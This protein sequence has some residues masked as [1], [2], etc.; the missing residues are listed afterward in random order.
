[1]SK[2][3]VSVL[4]MGN[5]TQIGTIDYSNLVYTC[6]KDDIAKFEL[7][8]GDLLF[9]RTNS[10]EWVGKTSLY[11]GKIPAIYAGYLIRIR[12]IG[13]DPNFLCMYMCSQYY[14]DW[15]LQ[16]KTDAVNQSNINAQKLSKLYC[17]IPPLKEQRRIVSIFNNIIAILTQIELSKSILISTITGIKS[18][19]LELAVQGKLV[20]QDPTDEPAADMLKRVNPKA[21]IITDNPHYP[22]LP[23]NWVLASLTDVCESKLGKTLNN[24]TDEGIIQ[25]YLCSINV[26]QGAFDL[27]VLKTAKIDPSEYERY[28]VYNGDLLI[29]E[30][31]DVGRCA[32]WKG[33]R[34][35]YQN[36][37]HRVRPL[38][39]VDQ[40][41]L[42]YLVLYAKN[43]LWIE[44]LSSGV[45]IK[46]FTTKAMSQLV[47]PIP[48]YNEQIRIV[49]AIE[50]LYKYVE[51]IQVFLN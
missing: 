7:Q 9:N 4:R 24:E 6:N 32:I 44:E 34:I 13:I 11:D 5:L 37:L 25:P 19:I 12:A 43:K 45:T 15:C 51:S 49:R 31:G 30:G 28:S 20:P 18:K 14:R 39:I 36:A 40:K 3:D 17:P 8:E 23:D 35:F 1:M 21:K 26:K 48:P 27:T 33:D 41:F 42:Y 38:D 46:H 50:N 16:V 22:K 10:S 29:C 47:I 2:G